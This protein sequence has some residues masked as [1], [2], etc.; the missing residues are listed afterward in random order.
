MKA[1]LAKKK[2]HMHLIRFPNRKEHKRGLMALLEVPH[3]FVGLPDYQMVVTAEHIKA[4]EHAQI[5]FEILSKTAPNGNTS[6]VQS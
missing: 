4:L 6:A 1:I 2:A 3:E 5:T